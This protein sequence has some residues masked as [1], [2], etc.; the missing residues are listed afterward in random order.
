MKQAD[1]AYPLGP[2]EPAESYLNILKIIKVLL[3]D[4]GLRRY[5]LATVCARANPGFPAA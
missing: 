1:E 5:I 2:P 3:K 4:V